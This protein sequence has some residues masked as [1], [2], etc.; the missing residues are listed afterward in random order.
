MTTVAPCVIAQGYT[1]EDWI[2]LL[3]G[4]IYLVGFMGAGKSTLG[5]LFAQELDY[6]FIDTDIFIESRFRKRIVDLFAQE[7]EH[8]FRQ[9]ERV[10]IEELS[11]FEKTVIS[12]GG[13]LPIYAHTME[14]VLLPSGLVIYLQYTAR[15]LANRLECC[16]RTRPKVAHL[17][18]EDLL[19]YVTHELSHRHPVYNRAHITLFCSDGGGSLPEKELVQPLIQV[20]EQIRQ[21]AFE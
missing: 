20:I 4:P 1:K 9:K 19:E 15:E 8:C 11:G 18:G 16:K 7:G 5:R 13:G 3:R 17:S 14:D 12:T 10:V 21:K 6:H 2:Q